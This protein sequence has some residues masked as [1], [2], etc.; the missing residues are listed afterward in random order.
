VSCTDLLDVEWWRDIKTLEGAGGGVRMQTPR[1]CG[2]VGTNQWPVVRGSQ[3]GTPPPHF[4]RGPKNVYARSAMLEIRKAECRVH[5]PDPEARDPLPCSSSSA[6]GCRQ[7][8]FS[9]E[10]EAVLALPV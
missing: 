8:E 4:L 6:D 10:S 1:R 9:D 5:G 3:S 2:Y 7:C